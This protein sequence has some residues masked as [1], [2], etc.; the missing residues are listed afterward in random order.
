MHRLPPSVQ[1]DQLEGDGNGRVCAKS[2]IGRLRL[3]ASR[4]ELREGR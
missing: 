2:P 1:G 3:E 4:Q